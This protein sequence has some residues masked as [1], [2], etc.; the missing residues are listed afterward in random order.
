VKAFG[1]FF[2]RLVD[3]RDPK[4]LVSQHELGEKNEHCRGVGFT[5]Y[6]QNDW[7]SACL[8]TGSCQRF[9]S[10]F[11]NKKNLYIFI[12]TYQVD[13]NVQFQVLLQ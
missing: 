1:G 2:Q 10:F 11:V 12:S 8:L 7:W 9:Y 4:G 13:G 3:V 6:A 5:C